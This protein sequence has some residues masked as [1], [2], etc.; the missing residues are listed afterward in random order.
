MFAAAAGALLLTFACQEKPGTTPSVPEIVLGFE[1]NLSVKPEGGEEG[2]SYVVESPAEDGVLEVS[3]PGTDWIENFVVEDDSV[4]FTVLP[5][6][7]GAAREAD[8][9][10][11]YTYDGGNTVEAGFTAVQAAP[12][13]IPTPYLVCRDQQ[14]NAEGGSVYVLWY[15][16][17]PAEDGVVSID[18][19]SV[20][21]VHDIVLNHDEDRVELTVDPNEGARREFSF[22]LVY[23][24]LGDKQV[25]ASVT[26]TQ[27]AAETEGP[28]VEREMLYMMGTYRGTE[29]TYTKVHEYHMYLSNKEF[30]APEDY[31]SA[32]SSYSVGLYGDAPED[33][34]DIRPAAKVY[35]YGT[36]YM[37]DTFEL[38]FRDVLGRWHT[39]SS[40][41]LTLEYAENGD[42][43]L[44]ILA[45]DEEG[46]QHR[47]TY[48]GP[49]SFTDIRENA[50]E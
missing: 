14:V 20:D 31:A 2:F 40:G 15:I 45:V 41:T 35:E 29:R 36:T 18:Y 25:S 46:E 49:V 3:A 47:A 32:S 24:Y 4:S 30:E 48:T 22:T 1:G 38:E 8:V 28:D 6:D 9:T 11:V 33:M 50:G 10:L 17:D 19:E 34:A 16:D 37:P 23:T 5:N 26:L 44:E 27:L 43:V 39:F 12:V 42:M 21:W 13:R 7:S